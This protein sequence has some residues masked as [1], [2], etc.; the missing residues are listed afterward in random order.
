MV[1]LLLLG[2]FTLLAA[3]HAAAEESVSHIRDLATSGHRPEALQL[4]KARLAADPDDS[5]I[6]VLFGTVLSWEGEYDEARRQLLM[7]LALNPG[8]NDALPALIN[9][10]LWSGHPET[11]E[12]QALA[13]LASRPD[14]TTLLFAHVK[15]LRAQHREKEAL[16]DLNHILKLEPNNRV[17]IEKKRSVRL[18]MSE[19]RA[20]F[21]QTYEWFNDGPAAWSES[22]LSL[23]RA[24][25][26][27]S[28]VTRFS[29]ANRYSYSSDQ[30]SVEFYPKLRP[31]AYA[32]LQFGYSPDAVLYPRYRIGADVYSGFGHDLGLEASVGFRR[33]AF[34][35]GIN[36]YTATLG[37]Y[38][39]DWLFTW[40]GFATPDES[41]ISKSA[42]IGARRYIGG[43]GDYVGVRAGKGSSVFDSVRVDPLQDLRSVSISSE[44][45]K[46]LRSRWTYGMKVGLSR[47]DR[48][49]RP[50]LRHYLL[51]TGIY[52]R[53]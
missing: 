30:A 16:Q 47:E 11:A 9:A 41:G 20:G 51:D 40:R 29:R 14:D 19:W 53:F 43:D 24:M 28:I 46:T 25:R 2:G 31:G 1:R 13:G 21:S 4:M 5:D 27:G 32:F 15:A 10:E 34:G 17:A 37:K 45:N 38:H 35:S 23:K 7:V 12:K 39:G 50:A 3:I 26:V 52:Y 48:L 8:H 49:G 6:R 22:E 36:I 44:L 18:D 33:L 42:S